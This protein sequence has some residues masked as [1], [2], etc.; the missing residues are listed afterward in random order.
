MHVWSSIMSSMNKLT[1]AQRVAVVRAFVEGCSIRATARMTAVS[2]DT[3][4]K[5]LVDMGAACH[6]MHDERVRGLRTA[7]VQCDEQWAFVGAKQKQ[8]ERG[9]AAYG[10]AWL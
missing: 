3:A 9:A 6:A 4:M 10:D 1:T 5:L 2:K 8:V 7:R